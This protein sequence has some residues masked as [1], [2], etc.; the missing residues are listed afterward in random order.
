M[1]KVNER[2]E[3][4]CHMVF[5][6]FIS[7]MSLSYLTGCGGSTGWRVSFGVS[8]VTAI[9]DKAELTKETKPGN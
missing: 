5:W 7:L 8:P 3:S 9:S 2:V 1:I 6:L 4:F